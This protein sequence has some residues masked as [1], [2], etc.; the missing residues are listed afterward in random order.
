MNFEFCNNCPNKTNNYF[1]SLSDDQKEIRYF[2]VYSYEPEYFCKLISK[3]K[4]Y[5]TLYINMDLQ[6]IRQIFNDNELF[7]QNGCP[8]YFEHQINDWNK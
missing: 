1:L 5:E 3:N 4:M 7:P 2:G 8:Y 6:K